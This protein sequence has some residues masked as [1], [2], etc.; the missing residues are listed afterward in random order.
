[1]NWWPGWLATLQTVQSLIQPTSQSHLIQKLISTVPS[2]KMPLM[3]VLRSLSFVV[4]HVTPGLNPSNFISA[5]NSGNFHCPSCRINYQSHEIRKHLLISRN[6]FLL[7]FQ[8]SSPELH[9]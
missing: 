8:L 5:K 4:A 6:D 1:M 7:R 3:M 9:H 2:V